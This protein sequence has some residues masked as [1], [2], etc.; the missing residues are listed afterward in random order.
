MNKPI[1]I[2]F[3]SFSLLFLGHIWAAANDFDLLFRVIASIIT[4]QV[5]FA[6]LIIHFLGDEITKTRVP[7][8]FLSFGLGYAYSGMNVEISILFW[9]I[10]AI[11]I[12][13]GSEK[14]LKYVKQA[15]GI[16]G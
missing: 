3:V 7:I 2:Y 4:I 6:G 9:L 12:Q 5:L 15:D 11:I 16:N 1:L 14:G 10:L 8:L 13:Y